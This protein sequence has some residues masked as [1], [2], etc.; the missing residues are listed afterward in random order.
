MP[1]V[2]KSKPAI[3]VKYIRYVRYLKN[4]RP[5][6]PVLQTS[7]GCMLYLKQ[8]FGE[9]TLGINRYCPADGKH[10]Q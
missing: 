5:V 3:E 2:P 10:G 1:A 8:I 6:L 9:D 7:K 4:R